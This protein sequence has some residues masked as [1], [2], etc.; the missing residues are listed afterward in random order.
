[1]LDALTQLVKKAARDEL[2]PR[3]QATERRFKSDGSI[4]TEAD[5]AMQRR[6]AAEL[7]ALTPTYPLLGE[8][9][10]EEEQR[11][12]ISRGDAGLWCLDPLDG[13]SNFAAGI[14]FFGVSLAL[15]MNREPVLGVVYDPLRDELF[16]A[17]RERG[18]SLNGVRLRCRPADLPL[19]RALAVV[20]FKRLGPVR[21]ALAESPPYASQRNFGSVVL[22]WC[23]LAASRY[24]VYLHGRQKLWDYAAGAL[25]LKEAGGHAETLWGEPVFDHT[26]QS[27]SVVA[28]ADPILFADWKAWLASHAG[29]PTRSD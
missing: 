19:R 8:E 15:L 27:R 5:L 12:L 17:E 26:L 25:I 24:H 18:A 16:A 9:M 4:V 13:T 2:L 29:Q 3:F 1:M 6:L 22:E 20:D 10:S 28:A 14:P 11:E 21:V 7:Q 23:W